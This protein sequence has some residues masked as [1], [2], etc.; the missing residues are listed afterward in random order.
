MT[1][2][3]HT[4]I[5]TGALGLL[6]ASASTPAMAMTG[7]EAVK[8]CKKNPSCEVA[9]NNGGGVIVWNTKDGTMVGCPKGESC[10][11]VN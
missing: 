3:L 11:V 9:A 7:S 2:I 8:A 10:R 4:L 6:V 1:T 5:L